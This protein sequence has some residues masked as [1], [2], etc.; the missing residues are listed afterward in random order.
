MTTIDN[1]LEIDVGALN[2]F[3]IERGMRI[4]NGYGPLKNEAFRIGHMGELGLPDVEK[5]L[6]A[7]D[8]FL[9]VK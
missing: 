6:A 4:A 3:L 5:L 9:K 8:E 1:K 7:L 2:A